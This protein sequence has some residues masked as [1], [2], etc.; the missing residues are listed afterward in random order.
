M[1]FPISDPKERINKRFYKQ[2]W[3]GLPNNKPKTKR[4][5]VMNMFDQVISNLYLPLKSVKIMLCTFTSF[6]NI[7]YS[8]AS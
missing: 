4:E 8:Y 3:G 6:I 2:K 1:I 5:G 7:I